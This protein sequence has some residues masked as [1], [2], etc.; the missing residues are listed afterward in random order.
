[1]STQLLDALRGHV[2]SKYRPPWFRCLLCCTIQY[3]PFPHAVLQLLMC[4][5]CWWYACCCWRTAGKQ[6]LYDWHNSVVGV[7]TGKGLEVPAVG[8]ASLGPCLWLWAVE[9]SGV[10]G[11]DASQ[12]T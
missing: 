3:Q 2:R 11:S 8:G 12:L 6:V 5:S 7:A 10:L 9:P 4:C 1:M